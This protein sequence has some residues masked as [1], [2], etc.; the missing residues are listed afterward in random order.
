M[1]VAAVRVKLNTNFFATNLANRT[2]WKP[3]SRKPQQGEDDGQL[4]EQRRRSSSACSAGPSARAAL[5]P[6]GPRAPGHRSCASAF[7]GARVGG[8]APDRRGARRR[9]HQGWLPAARARWWWPW[10]PTRLLF[11]RRRP[12]KVTSVSFLSL[13]LASVYPRLVLGISDSLLLTWSSSKYWMALPWPVVW[14]FTPWGA[15]R[16]YR[17]KIGWDFLLLF[18]KYWLASENKIE[19]IPSERKLKLPI[20]IYLFNLQNWKSL[21]FGWNP[22]HWLEP[23]HFWSCAPVGLNN[24]MWLLLN[25]QMTSIPSWIYFYFHYVWF[26]AHS[27]LVLTIG[28]FKEKV[29]HSNM[30]AI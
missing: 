12:R 29:E 4:R 7:G 17:L 16:T 15:S 21:V 19:W 9:Q 20:F 27:S 1:L 18:G 13:S 10:P 11:R 26:L 28:R 2:G 3:K 8:A 5:L 25:D 22:E 30:R 24:R 14:L 23:L 6:P